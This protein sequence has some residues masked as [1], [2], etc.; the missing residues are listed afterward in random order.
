VVAVV[1]ILV[2]KVLVLVVQALLVAV[3]KRALKLWRLIESRVQ[4]A[5]SMR[6]V[7]EWW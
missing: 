5:Q 2:Q 7:G 1:P 3:L 4:A 6:V